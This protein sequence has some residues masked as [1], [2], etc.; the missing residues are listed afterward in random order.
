MIVNKTLYKMLKNNYNNY[1]LNKN[2]KTCLFILIVKR[3][4]ILQM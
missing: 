4:K 2:E 3:L 1:L